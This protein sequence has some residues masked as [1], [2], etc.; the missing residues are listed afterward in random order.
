MEG[1][2]HFGRYDGGNWR[3]RHFYG[4]ELQNDHHYTSALLRIV[5]VHAAAP[6][7]ITS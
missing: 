1:S 7:H 2:F 4:G 6:G 5:A 3:G